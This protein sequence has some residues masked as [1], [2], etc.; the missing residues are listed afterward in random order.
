VTSPAGEPTDS[1]LA[2][3]ADR[4]A[5]ALVDEARRRVRLERLWQLHALVDPGAVGG[6]VRRRRLADALELLTAEG[7][8]RP[9]ATNDRRTPPLP[10]FVDVIPPAQ[11][12]PPPPPTIAWHHRLGWVATA[13]LSPAQLG[14]CR[15]VNGFLQA[16][17][18]DSPVVPMRERSLELFGDEKRLDA[19]LAGALFRTPGRLTLEL[20][21]CA[22]SVAPLAYERVGPGPGALVAENAATFH[23]LV[24]VIGDQRGAGP[25]G[26]VV[27]GQGRHFDASAHY[28]GQLTP[29]PTPVWYFGDLDVKGLAIPQLAN[30][31]L[32]AAGFAPVRPAVALYRLL[33][34]HGIPAPVDQPPAASALAG[35]VAWLPTELR[36]PATKLLANHRLAQEAVGYQRL[37]DPAGWLDPALLD[38]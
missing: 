16:D 17:G 10:R 24:R 23:S 2:G 37:R 11:P 35:L 34:T 12:D 13:T 1:D 33:L 20:L 4:L 7:T 26:L 9:A 15:Q 30:Q 22:P 38:G 8:L 25:V 28:L 27:F 14:I 5:A 36:D 6:P 32:A 21:R 3:L 18:E 29:A 31:R 19:L